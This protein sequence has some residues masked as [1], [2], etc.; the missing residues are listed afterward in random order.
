[1][2]VRAFER[3]FLFVSSLSAPILKPFVLH[4]DVIPTAV[5]P[6]TPSVGTKSGVSRLQIIMRLSSMPPIVLSGR[7]SPIQRSA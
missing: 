4:T 5:L 2:S 3:L 6:V 7:V 1:M